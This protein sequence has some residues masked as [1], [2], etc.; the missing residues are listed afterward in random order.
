MEAK[1]KK[2]E[3][4]LMKDNKLEVYSQVGKFFTPQASFDDES[5]FNY[6]GL[7]ISDMQDN[8]AG[9]ENYIA[10]VQTGIGEYLD[11]I[12]G[13]LR[14]KG[15]LD[16]AVALFKSAMDL[17]NSRGFKTITVSLENLCYI[18]SKTSQEN[19]YT[20]VKNTSKDIKRNK[21]FDA[22]IKVFSEEGYH[23]ATI[24]KI[25][26]LSDIGKGSV[27]RYF[28]SKKDLLDQLLAEN[29]DGIV[30]RINLIF[31][32]GNDV[33]RQV[34]EMI[35]FWLL[36]IEENSALYRLFQNEAITQHAEQKIFV[37]DYIISRLPMFKERIIAL[38][39]NR[40]LKTTSIYTVFY[41]VFGFID[42][43]VHKWF[44]ADKR[45]SLMDEKPVILEVIFNGFFGEKWTQ[46]Q[47]YNP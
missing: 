36:Y 42:G 22:A 27:Y 1:M 31:S 17:S 5:F 9:H 2:N 47:F 24:D 28:T 19:T 16:G 12:I 25:A 43:I 10:E 33:V 20:E 30:E 29:Y 39:Y 23:N 38:D 7:I 26:E 21:I 11:N 37:Y 8:A 18:L 44:R 15:M 14:E 6:F 32:V 4:K 35:D 46:K 45:Y 34:E 41:G 3:I 40:Q 13:Y